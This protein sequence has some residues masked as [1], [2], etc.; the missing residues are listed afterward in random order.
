MSPGLLE[1]P[2]PFL[3]VKL[4]I[5]GAATAAL[6]GG[7]RLLQHATHVLVGIHDDDEWA[8]ARETVRARLRMRSWWRIK[9]AVVE[10]RATRRVCGSQT[11]ENTRGNHG[12][13][14]WNMEGISAYAHFA[15]F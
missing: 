7:R 5:E 1:H 11:G 3:F 10:Q 4:D 8:A 13:W 14:R 15:L 9:G 2:P 6:A 12:A